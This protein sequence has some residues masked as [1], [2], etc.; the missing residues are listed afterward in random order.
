MF[1]ETIRT[2][3]KPLF[4]NV[5][6]GTTVR[7]VFPYFLRPPLPSFKSQYTSAA[8]SSEEHC[9]VK[10]K[11]SLCVINKALCLEDVLGNGGIAPPVLTSAL[12]GDE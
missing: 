1:K 12:D 7:S 11:L 8:S 2:R 10:V 9:K 3:C 6:S 5:T 4:S